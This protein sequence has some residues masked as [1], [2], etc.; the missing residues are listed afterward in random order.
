MPHLAAAGRGTYY[1]SPGGL[2]YR[3]DPDKR[4]EDSFCGHLS[5]RVWSY[6]T[7]DG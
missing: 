6:P 3:R 4:S 1:F 2:L 5:D 7:D